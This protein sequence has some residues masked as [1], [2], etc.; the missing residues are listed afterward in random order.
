MCDNIENDSYIGIYS[1][2]NNQKIFVQYYGSNNL[3]VRNII[4]NS[5]TSVFN[6]IQSVNMSTYE[7][8]YYTGNDGDSALVLPPI[9]NTSHINVNLASILAALTN[10]TAVTAKHLT[11]TLT[12]FNFLSMPMFMYIF[13]P[14]AGVLLIVGCIIAFLMI[15]KR[16][17]SHLVGSV[18]SR[19]SLRKTLS[20][21]TPSGDRSF[22]FKKKHP[23]R[24]ARF[25]RSKRLNKC[26]F[27]FTLYSGFLF[28]R[29]LQAVPKIEILLYPGH[30]SLKF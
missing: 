9:L 19:F 26:I 25:N 24:S 6:I 8:P 3:S 13:F 14:I 17:R 5:D 20:N 27:L 21:K 7:I 23:V 2:G 15:K 18:W 22:F 10:Y 16:K 1:D 12:S 4:I 28:W 30:E 29:I 11:D